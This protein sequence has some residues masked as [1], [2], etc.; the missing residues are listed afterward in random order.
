MKRLF[1]FVSLMFV[2]S[3]LATSNGVAQMWRQ[4]N[5]SSFNIGN[6]RGHRGRGGQRRQQMLQQFDT[7]GDGQLNETERQAAKTAMKAKMLEKFDANGDGVLSDDEKPQRGRG[8]RGRGRGGYSQNVTTMGP[9]AP[10]GQR[11]NREEMKA[12]LLEKFDTDG[13]GQLSETER[14]A[15]KA[16]R[17]AKMLEKFDAN[18]D[19]VLSD[20]EKPQR[21]RGR[22]HGRSG[23]RE[24]MKA[25]LLEK[26]DTDG[27]GQLS[28]TERQA[29]K[30]AR[31][32]LRNDPRLQNS[33]QTMK[34][35]H[36]SLMEAMRSGD[37]DAI[38]AAKEALS[39]ARDG[40]KT[41]RQ[42]YS[43][44]Y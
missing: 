33:K 12:K 22:R 37:A 16:A 43:N 25:K 32:A 4:R 8:R 36:Q 26:F 28:E 19:G 3:L 21:G 38:K 17:E 44:Q 35:A 29:A 34:E 42:E 20:D 39:Q 7:D 13:D 41:I 14:Q 31:E 23:N 18:G 9:S 15:A 1:V 30:A 2:I 10:G 5:S 11:F 6:R 24:E 27:D 40:F